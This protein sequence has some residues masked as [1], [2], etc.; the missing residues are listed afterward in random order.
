ME[1]IETRRESTIK[2]FLEVIFRRKW[3]VLGIVC[4]ATT[5]VVILNMKEPAVFESSAKVLVKRGEAPGAFG[6]PAR[7]LTWE[8]E[9][10]S[11]IEMIKSQVV[12]ERANELFRDFAPEGYVPKGR[13]QTGKVNAGVIGTSNVLWIS[14]VSGDP[15]Y[16]EV[17]VNAIINAYKDYYQKVRTPPEMEDFFSKE[18]SS[19]KKELEYW[20]DRKESVKREWGIV[21][22]DAQRVEI[23]R[24]LEGYRL[25]LEKTERER[26][27][28]EMVTKQLEEFQEF[29]I[30]G[31]S[32]MSKGLF[33]PAAGGTVIEILRQKMFDL[34][35][36]ESDLAVKYTGNNRKLKEVRAQIEDLYE[37]I[38]REIQVQLLI[39]GSKLEILRAK[40]EYLREMVQQLESESK[41]YP[42]REIEINRID[43]AL[44][45][46]E[47]N[48]DRL[49]H[50]HMVS[51][52]T[53]ASNPEWT[54]TILNPATRAYQQKTRDYVRMALGPLFSLAIAL[55]FAFFLENLDHSIKNI[56]E[57][58]ETLNLHVLAS[59]PEKERR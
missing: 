51:R 9:I 25:D 11:Q 15:I 35:V 37:L 14:Y 38:D 28:R 40:E 21:D 44:R 4:V 7:M 17:A 29:G 22:V 53:I 56:A 50:Q 27:E 43:I 55:G 16:C 3:I 36:L 13:M 18:L 48:Y 58:E 8:E 34:K 45:R 26:S 49:V 12:V 24:S 39:S 46:A 42:G 32:A 59:F 2:D 31:Q 10:S 19:L 41:E 57:A 47:E 6:S 23:L 33:S 5:F 52:M 30:D 1:K 54:I 20:R